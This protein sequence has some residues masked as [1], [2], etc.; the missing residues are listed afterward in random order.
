MR[1]LTLIL[2]DLYLPE[3]AGPGASPPAT[4]DLPNLEWLLR[5]ADS[6]ELIGD[7]RRWLL[8]RTPPGF[9]NLSVAGISAYRCIDDRRIESTWLATPVALEARLDHV[10]LLDRGLLRLDESDRAM[11]REEFGRVFGPAYELRDGGERTFYLCGL[12]ANAARTTDPARLLG[13]EIGPALPGREAH[14]L[15]R[16]WAEIEMWLHGAAFNAARERAGKRRVS[17]LWIWG[18][19]RLPG[20]RVESG[21][22]A[23][24]YL[25]SDPLIEGLHRMHG[26]EAGSAR[27]VPKRLADVDRELTDIVAE[28]AALTGEPRES[29]EALDENWFAPARAGLKTGDIRRVELV[30]N[31]RCFRIRA[32]PQWKVWRRHRHWLARLGS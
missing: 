18:G 6:P 22:N 19:D 8:D 5:F 12:P 28:F 4:H 32:R 27:S 16:L 26:G 11:C 21:L 31:D 13:T 7:W 14:E 24:A 1:R 29:L 3:E 30:A 23:N 15:R 9:L 25:G 20:R 10:R 2:S 17:A